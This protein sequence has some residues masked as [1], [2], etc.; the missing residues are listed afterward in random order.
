MG[1]QDIMQLIGSFGFPIFACIFLYISNEKE[2]QAHREEVT[3]LKKTIDGNTTALN[4]ILEHIRGID[5]DRK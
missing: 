4:L 3:E 1:I 2:T 5:D